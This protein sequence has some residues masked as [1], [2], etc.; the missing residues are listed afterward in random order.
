VIIIVFIIGFVIIK[1]NNENKYNSEEM[2]GM[3]R[4]SIIDEYGAFDKVFYDDGEKVTMGWYII[5]ERK[6]TIMGLREEK[7]FVVVFE[8]DL[9]KETY[10]R[11]GNIGG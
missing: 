4:S 9:A 1:K 10:E 3:T 6:Q 5:E 8:D 11:V 2:I 7:Y